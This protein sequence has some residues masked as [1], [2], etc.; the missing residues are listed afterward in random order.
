MTA[1]K[2]LSSF[3]LP[4]I[5][6]INRGEC[7]L[8]DDFIMEQESEELQEI[9]LGLVYLH[10]DLSYK[11]S[12]RQQA[13]QELQKIHEE[14]LTASRQAGMAEMATNILHDVG[15]VL[16]SITTSTAL[17]REQSSRNKLNSFTRITQMLADQ[18]DNLP[19]FLREKG[20]SAQIIEFMT[21]FA[22]H[23]R[24]EQDKSV[25]ELSQLIENLNHIKTIIRS[26]QG[27]AKSHTL[28]E[29]V[30]LS[31][32]VDTAIH[33]SSVSF[34]RHNIQILRD[35]PT[36]LPPLYLDRHRLLQILINLLSNAR[37][38]VRAVKD[39]KKDKE[40][41]LKIEATPEEIKIHVRDN[42]IGIEPK[43]A[44]RIFEHGFTTKTDGNGFGLHSSANAAALMGGALSCH[45]QGPN[46]GATFT[47]TLPVS[48]TPPAAN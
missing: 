20:R 48:T 34:A 33:L 10:E 2:N 39:N 46:H 29:R 47:L 27:Y 15:N 14:L 42:G 5:M 8:T 28:V 32:I 1:P 43:I 18:G 11:D 37:H 17:L 7:S 22:R 25:R 31:S 40:I 30:S 3:L 6:E 13:E 44:E 24:V 38:A 19:E 23:L 21:T 45:S 16:N 35:Y 41:E 26:H 12:Q 9:L 36:S 4:L